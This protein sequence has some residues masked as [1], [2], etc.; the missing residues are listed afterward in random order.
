MFA[1]AIYF[2]SLPNA[3]VKVLMQNSFFLSLLLF[4][5]LENEKYTIIYHDF[6]PYDVAR[7][8]N[9]LSA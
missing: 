6:T 3:M 2:S 5:F 4:D 1:Y 7:H 9:T 8:N